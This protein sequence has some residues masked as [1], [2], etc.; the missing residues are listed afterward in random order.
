MQHLWTLVPG[1]LSS[2][3]ALPSS[4]LFCLVFTRKKDVVLSKQI[5]SLPKLVKLVMLVLN[6]DFVKA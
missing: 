2:H 4:G 5:N 3:F 1:H 6:V